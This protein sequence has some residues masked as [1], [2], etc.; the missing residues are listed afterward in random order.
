MNSR[1]IP[2][3]ITTL[4][5][6]LLGGT[7]MSSY[8]ALGVEVTTSSIWSDWCYISAFPEDRAVCFSSHE[9]CKKAESSDRFKSDTC[10][11]HKS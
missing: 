2:V 11:N 1:G 4:S 8:S 5:T 9:E 7:I 10:F 6:L 3:I